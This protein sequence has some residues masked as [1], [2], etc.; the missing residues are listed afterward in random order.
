MEEVVPLSYV[1]DEETTSA[2]PI[3][4]GRCVMFALKLGCVSA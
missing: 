1:L 4:N 3:V 2:P